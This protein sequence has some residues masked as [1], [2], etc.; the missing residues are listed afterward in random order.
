MQGGTSVASGLRHHG[1][2]TLIQPDVL[3][4]HENR[5]SADDLNR[6]LVRK[7]V[8]RVDEFFNKYPS[9]GDAGI[10]PE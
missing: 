3:K 1:F 9:F 5:S 8:D 4:C 2:A 7:V 6:Q 10:V